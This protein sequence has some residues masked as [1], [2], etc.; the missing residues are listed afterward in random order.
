MPLKD[1]NTINSPM[2][3]TRRPS[4]VNL[5]CN[6]SALARYCNRATPFSV[7]RIALRMSS[8]VVLQ[9]S[10]SR[11]DIL[12]Q[13]HPTFKRWSYSDRRLDLLQLGVFDVLFDLQSNFA[14]RRFLHGDHARRFG[15]ASD[16][17]GNPRRVLDNFI[18]VEKVKVPASS[19]GFA[20]P[21]FFWCD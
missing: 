18:P 19:P 14:K 20:F 2:S 6:C 21:C 12:V 1:R 16:N 17:I 4:R 13:F 5:R 15:L 11:F 7:A 9:P 3:P 8:G 10:P